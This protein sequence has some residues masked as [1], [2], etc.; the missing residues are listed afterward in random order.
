MVALAQ[1]QRSRGWLSQTLD[2]Q[3]SDSLVLNRLQP[4]LAFRC[5]MLSLAMSACLAK[6]QVP[7][8]RSAAKM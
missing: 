7:Q 8:L 2:F 3:Y 1:V 6:Q 5:G 4:Y